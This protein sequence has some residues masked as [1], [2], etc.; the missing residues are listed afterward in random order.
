MSIC[1]YFQIQ[2]I[3]KIVNFLACWVNLYNIR[4][5]YIRLTWQITVCVSHQFSKHLFFKVPLTFVLQFGSIYLCLYN[6]DMIECYWYLLDWEFKTNIKDVIIVFNNIY[7]ITC[8]SCSIYH[9]HLK[10]YAT[11]KFV[12]IGKSCHF[13]SLYIKQWLATSN[14]SIHISYVWKLS[15]HKA[16]CNIFF[17]KTC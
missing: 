17:L 5:V 11:I 14:G 10:L 15:S 12:C 9:I 16:L 1:F 3:K 8:M 13:V 6:D 7:E 4:K 2:Q